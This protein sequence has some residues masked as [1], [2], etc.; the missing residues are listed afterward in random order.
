MLYE[1]AVLRCRQKIYEYNDGIAVHSRYGE[2]TYIFTAHN[3]V[4]NYSN[5]CP[6]S[7]YVKNLNIH[8]TPKF[9]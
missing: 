6:L 3:K 1:T 4:E 5:L 7:K 8:Q 9:F 2:A